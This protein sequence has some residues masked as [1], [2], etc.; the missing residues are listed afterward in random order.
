MAKSRPKTGEP[1]DTHQP[2][3]I[4]RLPEDVRDA[5]KTL[6]Y[7]WGLT[8]AQIE[9][10]SALPYSANWE[11]DR[12]GFVPW[13][14][15]DFEVLELFPAM[16]IPSTT[17]HRWNDLRVDQARK[18]VIDEGDA[19]QRF[20]EEL[21]ALQIDGM[22]D[23]VQNAMVREVFGVLRDTGVGDRAKLMSGLDSASLVLARLQRL[24]LGAKKLEAE[25]RKIALLE[26][27]EAA[28]MRR[29]EAET[30]RLSKKAKSGEPITPEDLEEARK[31]TF[32]F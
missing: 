1:R 17:V 21:G 31:R 15:L 28:A 2:L 29:L 7:K 9:Q 16:R 30:E 14:T 23:A 32:G 3:K 22:N 12:Q 10:R 27:R 11:K 4:D 20:C 19:A 25:S 6:R 24:Q 5:I 13:E 8:W 18:E 26:Q